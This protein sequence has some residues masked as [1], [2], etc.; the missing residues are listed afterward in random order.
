MG[1]IVLWAARDAVHAVQKSEGGVYGSQKGIELA[2][3]II[4]YLKENEG[5]AECFPYEII[6]KLEDEFIF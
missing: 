2:K 5:C 6:D 3:K 1:H 4:E